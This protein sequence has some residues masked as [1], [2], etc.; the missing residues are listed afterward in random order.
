MSSESFDRE[1]R[2]KYL[3]TRRGDLTT[4]SGMIGD[5]FSTMLNR[6][7]QLIGN[8]HEP[9]IG[10]YKERLLM[11]LIKDSVPKRYDVGTGF[12]L[13]PGERQ[14]SGKS[15]DEDGPWRLNGH[16]VSKQIDIIVYDSL[17]FP[18]VFKDGDFVIVRPESVRSIIE[19]K[20]SIDSKQITSFME[21]F[22]DFARKWAETDMYYRKNRLTP[23]C[24]PR[25]LVMN[26]MVSVD[27]KGRPRTNGQQLRRK[28]TDAYRKK[29]KPEELRN[30]MFPLLRSAYIY[31]DC[32]VGSVL[33]V[34]ND[35]DYAGYWTMR[36]K[37]IQYDDTT[38]GPL[39]GPDKTVSDLLAEIHMSLDTPQNSIFSH[40]DQCYW[41]TSFPHKYDGFDWCF[42][43]DDF[44][45]F[46]NQQNSETS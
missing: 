41:P 36:G 7:S 25:L 37:F 17:N 29:V 45:A 24:Y 35:E 40:V 10:A 14:F 32:Y 28:I 1:L 27:T 2:E 26:W 39:M 9:S 19:V 43:L 22:I 12:V 15:P 30:G 18:T 4:Y 6:L 5:G 31:D 38:G 3:K 46:S 23:L 44:M 20:G 13:F 34:I 11:R 16:K 8:A 33:S 21:L 42:T